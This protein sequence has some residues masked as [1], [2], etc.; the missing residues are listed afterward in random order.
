[1]KE[2]I[3]PTYYPEA[4]VIC[5]AETPGRR[6]RRR[7]SVPMC[8]RSAIRS[9]PV[10][11]ASWTPKARSTAS[12]ASFRLASSTWPERSPR[13]R[14]HLPDRPMTELE[15]AHAPDALTKAGITSVGQVLEKLSR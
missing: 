11:S 13:N 2:S 4:T 1:M 15:L 10:S 12:I 9:S 3:H 8:A 5:A 6:V 7:K 14:P